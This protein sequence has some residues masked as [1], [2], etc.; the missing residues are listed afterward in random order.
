MTAPPWRPL[1]EV[2][3]NRRGLPLHLPAHG[4]GRGL[5]PYLRTLLR[6]PPASWDLPELPDFGGPLESEGAVAEAQRRCAARLGA[7]RCWFGVNGASGLLQAA[8][9][10]L[11]PPGSR[12][13]LPRNLHRSLLHGCV[14][15]QLE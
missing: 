4:R 9:L 12:V 3:G 13:L 11:A 1:A 8:L 14:L 5:A 7:D 6:Q 2:L 10:G 15:G